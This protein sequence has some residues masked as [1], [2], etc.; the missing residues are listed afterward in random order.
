MDSTM[1]LEQVRDRIAELEGWRTGP[2]GSWGR[3]PGP[4]YNV[5]HPIPAT[6][7]EAA[8]LPEGFCV[9]MS[10]S[11]HEPRFGVAA[12]PKSGG[13]SII[14]YGPTELESRFRLRLAVLEHIKENQ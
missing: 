5:A 1:T 2:G 12:N 7:D 14:A 11:V 4:G 6:L 10:E 13:P 9:S 3:L 8:K